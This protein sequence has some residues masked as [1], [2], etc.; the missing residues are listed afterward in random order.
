MASTL[1]ILGSIILVCA[2]ENVALYSLQRAQKNPSEMTSFFILG[3]LIYGI[4][5]PILLM[6][7]LRYA[8][9]GE[10]N[11]FWNILSILSGYAIGIYFFREQI[12]NLQTIG[13][14]VGVLGIGLV[15]MGAKNKI[16]S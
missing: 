11:F 15:I 7:A 8:D 16:Q 3:A 10:M 1:A 13:V 4:A 9:V 12:T 14:F 2:I 6:N 5:V